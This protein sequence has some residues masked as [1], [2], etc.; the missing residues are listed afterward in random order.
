MGSS[1][2]AARSALPEPRPGA[3]P[4]GSQ[5]ERPQPVISRSS[6]TPLPRRPTGRL[7]NGACLL[8]GLGSCEANLVTPECT[9]PADFA[10]S[11]TGV[12]DLL[13]GQTF[14]VVASTGHPCGVDGGELI[15]RSTRPQV[16]TVRA[17]RACFRL[18]RRSRRMALASER[19][20]P[21]PCTSLGSQSMHKGFAVVAAAIVIVG[22]AP[23]EEPAE[24]PLVSFRTSFICVATAD[25]TL[26]VPVEIAE[27]DDQ[28][29]YGLME[30]T[31]LD[32][33]AG[34]LFRYTEP[35]PAESGF[36]MY[37]TRIPLDIAFIDSAGA[38]RS[39]QSM[40]PCASP[41]PQFCRSYPAGTEF[42]AAMRV[43]K[44]ADSRD[45]IRREES[46]RGRA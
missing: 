10:I 22:C 38:I 17:P 27:N 2:L 26:R 4:L 41:N 37:R 1:S 46:L 33:G 40:E 24:E 9:R 34:M 6:P 31:R 23:D 8:L 14:T 13:P 19:Q 28:R 44:K 16:A 30:R 5:L 21:G 20:V 39:I 36:W 45:S 32:P 18:C 3:I 12:V 11:P 42:Q 35:Q 29:A 15:W 43:L 25:D 7:V